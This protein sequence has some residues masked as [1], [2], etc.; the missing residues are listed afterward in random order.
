[1]LK[2]KHIIDRMNQ[3][4]ISSKMIDLVLEYGV[5]KKDQLKYINEIAQKGIMK[6]PAIIINDIKL[7]HLAM[8]T[9]IR[10]NMPTE[11]DIARNK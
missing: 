4:G 5:S 10:I 7:D 1:M 2:T 3:R 9:H 11:K 6:N 8:A